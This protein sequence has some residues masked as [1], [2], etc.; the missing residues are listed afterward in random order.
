MKCSY[1]EKNKLWGLLIQQSSEE[2]RTRR[3]SC[4]QI[5]GGEQCDTAAALSGN[6]VKT[7]RGIEKGL[8]GCCVT[9]VR[10]LP[11]WSVQ[12]HHLWKALTPPPQFAATWQDNGFFLVPPQLVS[13]F[14]CLA[15]DL[16]TKRSKRMSV[17]TTDKIFPH[18]S[19]ACFTNTL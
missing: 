19:T 8:I 17:L 3:T 18:F 16:K 10:W 15:Q 2:K 11:W 1:W 4:K 5:H 13:C 14:S 7:L 12:D 6:I 9:A